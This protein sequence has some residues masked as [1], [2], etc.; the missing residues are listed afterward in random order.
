MGHCFLIMKEI[1][2][3]KQTNSNIS[4]SSEKKGN[5]LIQVDEL[6]QKL[7]NEYGPIMLKELEE[8]LMKTIND[9][10]SDLKS[11][12]ENAF[13]E[14]K[15]KYDN[16]DNIDS[17]DIEDKEVPSFISNRKKKKD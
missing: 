14:H 10:Q 16:L 9:F 11:I 15:L 6:M 4:K 17:V 8:R 7:D 5:L 12:L 3:N 1:M 2:K 13:N